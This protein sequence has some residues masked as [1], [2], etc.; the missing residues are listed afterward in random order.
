MACLQ[1]KLG[2]G[3]GI[4]GM[5]GSIKRVGMHKVVQALVQ[6]CA[7]DRSSHFL[8]VGAGLGRYVACRG[9]A[10]AQVGWLAGPR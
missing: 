10:A 9:S 7:L 8:D 5:Y 6:E 4:E 2:G 3:E 1:G